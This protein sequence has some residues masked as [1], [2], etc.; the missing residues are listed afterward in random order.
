MWLP[1]TKILIEQIKTICISPLA[2]L[3]S[4]FLLGIMALLAAVVVVKVGDE[5]QTLLYTV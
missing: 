5:S 1:V 4:G 3:C 2:H